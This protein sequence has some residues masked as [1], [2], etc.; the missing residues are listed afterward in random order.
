AAVA[1]AV[2]GAFQAA[3]ADTAVIAAAVAA[4]VR[5]AFQ[6]AHADTADPAAA[7]ARVARGAGAARAATPALAVEAGAVTRTAAAT[8]T[9]DYRADSAGG[10]D[11]VAPPAPI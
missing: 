11:K 3:H 5:G 4:A 7:V 2:R 10:V 8:A 1:I 9:R 6:A